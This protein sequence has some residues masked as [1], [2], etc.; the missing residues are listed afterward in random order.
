MP[1]EIVWRHWVQRVDTRVYKQLRKNLKKVLEQPEAG[2][3]DYQVYEKLTL[4]GGSETSDRVKFAGS[5]QSSSG[6]E[7]GFSILSALPC[8]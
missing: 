3:P 7:V 8:P 1:A 5:S 4:L 6:T 2:P